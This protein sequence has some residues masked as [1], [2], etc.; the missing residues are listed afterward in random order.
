MFHGSEACTVLLL[1]LLLFPLLY[2]IYAST[3]FIEGSNAALGPGERF[4]DVDTADLPLNLHCL[5]RKKIRR[6]R[7][8]VYELTMV[9]RPTS[10][11]LS[12]VHERP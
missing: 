5:S 12:R 7:C 6:L 2:C 3:L 1:L 4:E 10:G 8:G 9:G 11:G